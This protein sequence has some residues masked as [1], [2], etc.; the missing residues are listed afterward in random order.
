MLAWQLSNSFPCYLC[1]LSWVIVIERL[2]C[3]ATEL[4]G[5]LGNPISPI[6]LLMLVKHVS[7]HHLDNIN[8]FHSIWN[9]CCPYFSLSLSA[10]FLSSSLALPPNLS[11]FFGLFPLSLSITMFLQGETIR[12][13]HL[14]KC[15]RGKRKTRQRERERNMGNKCSR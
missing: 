10:V 1:Y 2:A 7:L 14:S 6:S 15:V 9:T 3:L 5:F 8:V 12:Q 4:L 11:L 13:H